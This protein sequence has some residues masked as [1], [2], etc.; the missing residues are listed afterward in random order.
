MILILSMTPHV[1]IVIWA[2]LLTDRHVFAGIMCEARFLDV[3]R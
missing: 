3:S 1:I 2:V